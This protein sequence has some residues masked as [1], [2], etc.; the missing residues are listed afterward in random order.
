MLLKYVANNLLWLLEIVFNL[1]ILLF[2]SGI[3]ITSVSQWL[4]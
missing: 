1:T 4:N 3:Y 2:E